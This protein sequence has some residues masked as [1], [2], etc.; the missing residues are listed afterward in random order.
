MADPAA[1][2]DRGGA[3]VRRRLRAQRRRGELFP[4]PSPSSSSPASPG[5]PR[6]ARQ[7][8]LEQRHRHRRECGVVRSLN[9]LAAATA[10]FSSV[11]STRGYGGGRAT[12]LQCD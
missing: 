8:R 10:S 5:A 12:P 2:F 4:L 6:C 1:S 9:Q 11:S 3:A 7:R